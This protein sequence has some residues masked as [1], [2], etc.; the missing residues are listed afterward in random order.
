MKKILQFA[1]GLLLSQISLNSNAQVTG[2]AVVTGISSSQSPY[3]IPVASNVTVTSIVTTTDVIAGYTMCGIP[4]GLGAFDNND[5]TFTLL[6]NHEINSGGIVRAHGASGAFVSKWIISK[7]SKNV[8][9]GSDLIQSVYLNAG[10]GYTLT[11]AVT[12]TRFCSA[13]LPATSAFWNAT[14]G[15]GTQSRIFMNGEESGTEGRA[16]A[17]VVNGSSAGKS[18]ELPRLGKAAWEN[19]VASPFSGTTTVVGLTDDG[20]GGQV[21]FYVGT[22]TNTGL[23]VDKAGLTNGNLW[24]LSVSSMLTETSTV[25]PPPNTTFSLIN[26]GDV[27]AITGASLNTLSTN[28]GVTT[29]LRPEDGTWDPKNPNVFYFV[30]TNAFNAPSKL[31]KCVFTNI[32]NPALGGSITA[33]LDGTEGQNMLDNIGMEYYGNIVLQEDIGNQA[34]LGKVFNYNTNTDVLTQIMVHDPARFALP[35]APFTQ[36]EESS[37]VIDMQSILGN[38]W[39]LTTVQAHYPIA[40]APVEGGQLLAFYNPYSAAMNSE[41]SVTTP[42]YNINNNSVTTLTANLTNFGS[43]ATNTDATNTFSI[44]NAGP[45]PLVVSNLTVTG[46]NASEFTF[47]SAP[48]TPFTVAANASQVLNIK[49]TPTAVGNRSATIVI[50]NN[51]FDENNFNFMVAGTGATV[52]TVGLKEN[53]N[54]L[55]NVVLFPNPTNDIASIKVSFSKAEHVVINVLDI[56]GK[57]VLSSEKDVN[58]G[59]QTINLNTSTLNN[60]AYFVKLNSSAKGTIIKMVV[61]H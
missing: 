59:E 56:L 19:A 7:A 6:M 10:T 49:F 40:G 9:Q 50:T 58:N 17:H 3:L 54:E 45:A 15:L 48:S 22:K 4:D 29:F 8:I 51:D 5:G 36:D 21:Y 1:F 25:V 32:A 39:F 27:S 13:D 31:W 30:T 33:V 53:T 18:Y 55:S 20:T 28:T 61:T 57:V 52:S 11:P 2:T 44:N 42:S 37:G 35:T 12:F 38:G 46:A 14:S 47:V 26:L 41:I 16:F 23:D 24:G 60:G 34:P 43:V